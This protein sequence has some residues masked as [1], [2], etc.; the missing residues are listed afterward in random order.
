MYNPNSG[1]ADEFISHQEILETLQFAQKNANNM[2]M[3]AEIMAKAKDGK[4]LT[5]REASVLLECPDPQV[6]GE[7]K[8]IAKELKQRLYGNRIVMFAP[9]YLSNYCINGCIYCPYHAKNRNIARK[10]LSQEEIYNEVV[11]LQ[12][13]GHK[14]LVLEAGEH[15]TLNTMEYIL[16]SI[17]TVYKIQN[18]NGVIRRVNINIAATTVENYRKL[19]EANIGTYILF[20]ET[21]NK[22]E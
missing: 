11:A 1:V 4:G 12:D 15:P 9:L 17:D 19:K 18:K 22:T 20:Q 6:L 5:H 8:A 14:R 7:V 10:K 2:D 16:E 21:Y 3:I 13:M